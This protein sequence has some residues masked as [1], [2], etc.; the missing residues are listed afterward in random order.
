VYVF[1]IITLLSPRISCFRLA[2]PG[3][4]DFDSDLNLDPYEN[5]GK[6]FLRYLEATVVWF[7]AIDSLSCSK[8]TRSGL[9][10]TVEIIHAQPSPN[11]G[12]MLPVQELID[13]LLPRIAPKKLYDEIRTVLLAKVKSPESDQFT[14]GVHCGAMLMG[15]TMA[16]SS[17]QP[18]PSLPAEFGELFVV[19]LSQS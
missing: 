5:A 9:D 10:L 13:E 1:S 12:H 16:C 14:G 11:V 6:L 7:S 4:P 3:S 17:P 2:E 15:I 8:L 18:D 19:N